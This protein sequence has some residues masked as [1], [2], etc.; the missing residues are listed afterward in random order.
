MAAVESAPSDERVAERSGVT[1]R[2][3]VTGIIRRVPVLDTRFL[4]IITVLALVTRLVWV[5]WVHPPEHYVFSDMRKYVERAQDLA[6]HGFRPGVRTLAWQTW[7]THYLLAVPLALFGGSLKVAGVLWGLMSAA[8]VPAAYLLS[9]RVS[10]RRWIPKA[11]GVAALLW[12]PN[13]SNSGY[14]LSEA[15]FLCFQLWSTYLLVVVMQDGRRAWPAGIV[16][17]IAFAVRPQAS[18]FFVLVFVSW[19]VNRKRLPHVHPRHLLGV[20]LPL[21]LTLAFSFY[22]FHAH[23]G[24]WGGVAENA[25]M[26]FTAGRCHN[27]VTQAFKNQHHLERSRKAGNTKNG[28]RVSLPGF[29]V[30][31][32]TVDKRNPDSFFALRPA[33]ESET[34]RFVGYVGDPEIHRELR[35]RCYDKTGTLGQIRYSI[36]NTTLLWFVGHQWPEIEKN[37]KFFYPTI[38]FYKYAYQIAIWVPSLIGM[39][40]AIVWIRRYPALTFCGWQLVTSM[41]IA[42]IFFGSIR[43]RTPYDPYAI[44]LALE[45]YALVGPWV[46]TRFVRPK[47]PPPPPP[48][49]EE[50]ESAD[51]RADDG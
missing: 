23:T 8:A 15:P 30:L 49:V 7:G 5:I 22:R 13:M 6:M 35:R 48:E 47:A 10:T 51:E 34:I 11:V 31:A 16:S 27:I 2:P 18:L 32:R 37:R 44:I 24:Y 21:L 36:V 26:N 20:A 12:H 45:A 28:R 3:E 43:L 4:I 42:S 17:A 41:T 38:A 40:L 46:W 1:R 33:M 39:V 9:C 29:R 50:S 14:F 25:N 19:A